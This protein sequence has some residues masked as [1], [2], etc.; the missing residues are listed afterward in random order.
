MSFWL[1]PLPWAVKNLLT[2]LNPV[3]AT[4]LATVLASI[5]ATALTVSPAQAQMSDA[6]SLNVPGKFNGP[7]N[8]VS[9]GSSV[10]CDLHREML[11]QLSTQIVS[12]T[13]T[14]SSSQSVS[15]TRT[16]A[17]SQAS[18]SR[19]TLP[20]PQVSNSTQALPSSHTQSQ[21]P[22]YPE[23]QK[24]HDTVSNTSKTDDL[25]PVSPA[26]AVL[27]PT[28]EK[29]ADKNHAEEKPT[30]RDAL[31]PIV[32]AQSVPTDTVNE[33]QQVDL[34]PAALP[35]RTPAF[36]RYNDFQQR[37]LY[38][39]PAKM[40]F[41]TVIENS[42]RLETNVFQTSPK[43]SSDMIYRI[44]PNTNLGYEIAKNTQIYSNYFFLRDQYTDFSPLLNRN[45]H[46]IGFGLN[47]FVPLKNR[48]T[49]IFGLQGRGLFATL[50][51]FPGSFFNDYLPS[52]TY[53]K[54]I[55]TNQFIYASVVG[56]LRFRE[57]CARFQ[58]GDIFYTFGHLYRR[59]G[60]NLLNNFTLVSNFGSQKI[61]QGPD[62]QII[63][64][65]QEL[66]RQVSRKLP[67]LQT[68]IR[69]QEIFNMGAGNIPFVPGLTAP[70]GGGVY[71]GFAGVNCRVFA[72]LRATVAKP[73]LQQPKIT[74]L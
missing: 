12:P 53:Q 62:T 3:L 61:R 1:R 70:G 31:E 23:Q 46:S 33:N 69:T 41:N 54:V 7:D 66:S 49:L 21:S 56:Q 59:G 52:I 63:I 5:T 67:W 45:F 15:Q 40:F 27:E 55:G 36:G 68:F 72:G 48:S 42:L 10:Y 29:L 30:E 37:A 24:K 58:E 74:G 17:S 14:L 28:V 22:A 16:P 57:M 32:L 39:L 19:Q 64:L 35:R 2:I 4:V 43:E 47:R 50:D 11:P 9:L 65:E 44:L 18:D 38:H 34:V 20:P 6:G 8:S 73:V 60:W 26:T 51:K 13:Q 25:I 71:P